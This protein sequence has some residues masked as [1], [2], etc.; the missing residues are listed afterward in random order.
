[1][2]LFSNYFKRNHI[3]T[4]RELRNIYDFFFYFFI[5]YFFFFLI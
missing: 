4:R 5:Y 1:M 2:Q 3:C